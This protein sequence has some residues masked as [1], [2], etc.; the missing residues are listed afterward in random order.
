MHALGMTVSLL[1]LTQYFL[2]GG[3]LP[4]V[5]VPLPLVSDVAIRET[6]VVAG[7]MENHIVRTNKERNWCRKLDIDRSRK[8]KKS[9]GLTSRELQRKSQ[10]R[11]QMSKEKHHFEAIHNLRNTSCKVSLKFS[12]TIL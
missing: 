3:S 7:D 11:Q 2:P 10:Q 6:L 12:S 9:I 4:T 8:K 1:S 5:W